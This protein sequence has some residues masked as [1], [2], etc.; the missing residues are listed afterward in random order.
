[1]SEQEQPEKI[2]RYEVLSL[3]GQGGMGRVYLARDPQ[4][5]DQVAIKVLAKEVTKS[6]PQILERVK[7]ESAALRVLNHPNIVK[8][9][10]VMEAEDDYA[11]VLEYVEGGSLWDLLQKEGQLSIEQVLQ[12]GLELADALTRAH[13]LKIIH[14][15]IKPANVLLTPEGV[16]KL[17]DFGLVRME[18][19]EG[20][21]KTGTIMGSVSYLSPEAALDAKPDFR[22]DIWAF[23]IVLYELLTGTRP[24]IA[25]HMSAILMKVLTEPVPPM[26]IYRQDIPP[27]LEM[28]VYQML[29]KDPEKRTQSIRRVGAELETLL[30]SANLPPSA[31]L[32]E[33]FLLF[34]ER[35]RQ[36]PSTFNTPTPSAALGLSQ[37]V[38]QQKTEFLATPANLSSPSIPAMLPIQQQK[39][40]FWPIVAVGIVLAAVVL[41]AVYFFLNQDEE[42]E[43]PEQAA[44]SEILTVE[45]VAV[46]EMMILVAQL[47]PLDEA[48]P[49][50]DRF[51]RNNL[52]QELE[53]G[54]P[55]MKLRFREYPQIITSQEDAAAAAAANNAPLIIWGN[56]TNDYLEL[57]IQSSNPQVSPEEQKLLTDTLDVRVRITDERS[58]TIAPQVLTATAIWWMY[59]GDVFLAASS[60]VYLDQLKM[61]GGEVMG[62][63]VATNVHRF[64]ASFYDSNDEA[65]Q[66]LEDALELD[67]TNWILYLVRSTA[68]QRDGDL[69]GAKEDARTAIRLS[70]DQWASYLIL[71]NI[72]FAEGD[73]EA[74]I[75]NLGEVAELTENWFPYSL[76][77]VIHYLNGNYAEAQQDVDKAMTLQPRGNVPYL[78]GI[79]LALRDGR[80]DDV[81][82]LLQTVLTEYPDPTSFTRIVETFTGGQTYNNA[83]LLGLMLSSFSNMAL[84]QYDATIRETQQAIEIRNDLPEIYL[85]Q[86][87]AYCVQGDNE[88]AEESYTEGIAL[89]P[90]LTVLYVLRADARRRMNDLTGSLEDLSAAQETPMWAG[91]QAM[92]ENPESANL[93]CENFFAPSELP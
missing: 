65:N 42:E 11:I 19:D 15:D 38:A 93:G 31:E 62:V 72:A 61:V 68:R 5:G 79:L 34:L 51:I 33:E 75:E 85:L 1:M 39:R 36:A 83:D 16:P 63:N 58:Q 40:S 30:Q 23:G 78:F 89:D 6:D 86:G 60:I 92:V 43:A 24:F 12:I 45:P 27:K 18:K 91:F 4:T 47:E 69:A 13:H 46:D 56:Y 9:L 77:G 41:G 26:S 44:E 21:T 64:Y 48:R 37:E 14:R 28:L 88:A 81:R 70:E 52:T 29:E 20:L 2:G 59:S 53:V 76:S 67:P 84:G 7:R 3:I 71:A 10:E 32:P 17:T 55:L 50:V 35:Q 57:D 49:N 8:M 82:T 54:A 80:M 90:D 66:A 73:Y 25:E 22:Q 87:M 74:A